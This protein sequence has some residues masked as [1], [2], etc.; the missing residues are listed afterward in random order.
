MKEGRPCFLF[1]LDT[2]VIYW[3]NLKKHILTA[4]DHTTKLDYARM[5]KNKSSR[6][7]ADFLYRLGYLVDQPRQNLQ[8]NN[9]SEFHLEFAR[10]TA[11]L[12]IQ[13]YCSKV[14]PP[15]DNPEIKKF[16]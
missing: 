5:Y 9:G 8:T 2:I 7:T 11:K 15:K 13:R 10:A 1:Q 16:N 3:N 12:S 6:M 4:V 14:K